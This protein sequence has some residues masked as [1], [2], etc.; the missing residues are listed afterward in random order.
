MESG[1]HLS[2]KTSKSNDADNTSEPLSSLDIVKLIIED[3]T[4]RILEVKKDIDEC[5]SEDRKHFSEVTQTVFK[6]LCK[7]INSIED[8]IIDVAKDQ[9]DKLSDIDLCFKTVSTYQ[10]EQINTINA[11]INDLSSLINKLKECHCY[12][13]HGHVNSK[14]LAG[15]NP[16]FASENMSNPESPVEMYAESG[17]NSS[18]GDLIQDRSYFTVDSSVSSICQI[19]GNDTVES[20]SHVDIPAEVQSQDLLPMVD[21]RTQQY[22][23]GTQPEV[24]SQDILQ[25]VVNRTQTDNLP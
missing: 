11:K 2:D 8:Y 25:V 9:N 5:M 14:S 1:V 6:E 12:H 4:K 17:I 16:I 10:E 19:D 7:K 23:L 21:D 18:S 15:R 13:I 3:S 24:Q 22:Q 20:D